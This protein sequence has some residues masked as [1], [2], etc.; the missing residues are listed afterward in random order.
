VVGAY[1]ALTECGLFDEPQP[2]NFLFNEMQ[3]LGISAT[4]NHLTDKTF[5]LHDV[6]ATIVAREVPQRRGG[7]KYS[8]DQQKN[9]RTVGLKSGGAF[10]EKI[11]I[12][13]QLGQGTGDSFSDEP[14]AR[15]LRELRK[16]FKKI[17][18]YYV[19]PY[20]DAILKSGGRLTINV[21]A[22]TEYDLKS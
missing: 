2:K 13:G 4:G 22:S 15:L 8:I 11:V 7:V 16:Q 21:A 17:N 1:L 9:S 18:S 12:A 5:L 20:A 14:A 3:N 19:G 10:G 6:S